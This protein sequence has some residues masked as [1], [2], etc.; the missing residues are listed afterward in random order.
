LLS[1]HDEAKNVFE[2]SSKCVIKLSDRVK[3][4]KFEESI[5]RMTIVSKLAKIKI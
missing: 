2:L 3:Y 5:E 1:R 4:V